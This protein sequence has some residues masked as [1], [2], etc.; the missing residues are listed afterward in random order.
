L[1]GDHL[2]FEEIEWLA[3]GSLTEHGI[4]AQE[5]QLDE[6][7]HHLG[8]CEPC[9]RLLQMYKDFQR[10][11]GKL[12]ATGTIHLAKGCPLETAW[13]GLAAGQLPE[14]RAAELLEHSTRCDACG[15]LLRQAIQDFAEEVTEQEFAD[16]STLP[17]AQPAWQQSLAQRLR[18][19]HVGQSVNALTLVGRRARALADRFAWQPRSVFRSTWAYAAA[20]LVFLGAGAWLVQTRR[21]PSIDQLI[22]SAYVEQRPFELRISGAAQGPVRQERGGERSAFAEPAG[23]LKAKYL[24]KERLAARPDDQAILVASGRVELLEGHYDEAIRTFGRL[25]DAHPDSPALLTDLAT[26]Y[27]QRAEAGDRAVDYGQAIELLGRALTKTPDDPLTLFN[28]AIAL[29]KI[30]AYNEAIRDWEHYLRVDPSGD[31]AT[32][33]R[34]RLSE[35]REKMKAR[36]RPA[37]LLQSDPVAAAPLLRARADGQSTSPAPW[38]ASFDEEYLDLVVRQWLASLYVSADSST[39]Q[40]WRRDPGVWDALTVA[41]DVLRIR[42]KDPWLADLLR[43]LPADS[44]PP[45]AVGPFVKALNFLAQA[46]KANASGDPDSAQLLAESAARFFYTAAKSDAGYLRA[47]EEII[48]SLVRAGQVQGCIQAAGRQLRET[49]LEFYPWLQGQAILW[50]AACQGFAGNLGLAQQ[51]SERA[52]EFTKNTAYA[53]Q[54]LRSVLFASGFLNSTER[55]WQDTRAGLQRFWEDLHNPF[56]GYES[57]LELAI[58]AE[59]AEQRHLAFHLYR[60]ALGM[61]EKTPDR[62][63]LAVAHYR[64]AVAAMRVENLTE[65]EEEFRVADQQFA[66]LSHTATGRLYRTLAEIQWAAVAVQQGR[67]ELAAARLEQARPLLGAIPDTENAFRYYQTLGELHFRRGKLPEAEHALRSALNIAETELGSLRTDADRLGWERDASPAYRTLVD[68]YARKPEATIRAL[69]VWEEYLASPLRRS[70][71][72]SLAKNLDPVSLDTESDPRFLLRIRAALPAF[73]HETVISFV[74]LPSGVAAWAFD[75]R[76]VNFARIAASNEELGARVRDFAHLCAD[77]YS[78]LANLQ[79]ESRSLYDLL[80]APFERSL[81]PSRLLIVEP[82]SILSDVP[83]PALIDPQRE[84]L[85]SRFAIVVSPGLGYWLNLRSTAAISPEKTALVVGMPAI[86]SVVASRFAALP[87]ADREARSVAAQF[88]HS[89]LLSGTEA[90][91]LTI[92]EE[93]S[94]SQVFHFAGHAISSV[95]QSGL[96]LASL[97]NPDGNEDE[98]TVLSA[99]DL[100]TAALQR[101]QL[102]VLSACATAETEKGFIGP[103][104]LVRGFLRA[105][106]PHVIASR[107][108]VDSQTT[109]QTMAEFYKGLFQGQPSAKALQQ[110]ANTVRNQSGASHPYYWAA[111]GSYGR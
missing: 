110:A 94:Q 107:W 95:Q 9:Q 84:Y 105:G 24:I 87:D 61:I 1:V 66:A 91:S 51:L 53:G 44:A 32:E 102:V 2:S 85:G 92:Q 109:Q 67:L 12:E 64:L 54:Y 103:D 39:R 41:A 43:E 82:D 88:R 77:P 72:S 46:A 74:S 89:R 62:S 56:H 104:T 35:L 75:D 17:S 93:L 99:S 11:L 90:T 4:P 45:I 25:L 101:L 7:R 20:A 83:W 6:A 15:L 50:N 40:S 33:A 10:R 59:E 52:L 81:E 57:Y 108:P 34:G 13:W 16:V 97:T 48:Y 27:F 21:E 29:E 65:A 96:V 73:K 80:V 98:P 78:D 47:R 76:G 60:E 63:Y 71:L 68:L 37:A 42:H 18:A 69:E 100:E 3:K 106:V 30:Y 28:R 111:F 14:P 86:A 23:L 49:K 22:A 79:Q 36:D 38:P 19:A 58:L 8:G 55:H 31:W 26:A 5:A 70:G